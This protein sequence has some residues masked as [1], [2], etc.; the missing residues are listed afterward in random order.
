LVKSCPGISGITMGIIFDQ[1]FDLIP[2]LFGEIVELETA[3]HQYDKVQ[4]RLTGCPEIGN[5][6][7]GYFFHTDIIIIEIYAEVE[8]FIL[9]NFASRIYK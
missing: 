6:T 8:R 9:G 2:L 7:S 4:E 1:K 3:A 5:N